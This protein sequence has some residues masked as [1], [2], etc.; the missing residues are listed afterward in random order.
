MP[1]VSKWRVP[2]VPGLK[3]RLRPQRLLC[4]PPLPLAPALVLA[5]ALAL[6]LALEAGMVLLGLE[7]VKFLRSVRAVHRCARA[8]LTSRCCTLASDHHGD[9]PSYWAASTCSGCYHPSP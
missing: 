8:I 2:R 9:R 1:H 5:L 4:L 6:A 3:Q 7:A